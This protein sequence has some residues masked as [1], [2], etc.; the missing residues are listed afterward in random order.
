MRPLPRLPGLDVGAVVPLAH[1]RLGTRA[2]GLK[3]EASR[4]PPVAIDVL[5][6]R[7][8]HERLEHRLVD[9]DDVADAPVAPQAPGEDVV[10]GMQQDAL[11]ELEDHVGQSEPHLYKGS[12]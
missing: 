3:E 6:G 10:G 7:G 4:S 12:R 5:V 11:T 9:L 1:G 2:E 8:H